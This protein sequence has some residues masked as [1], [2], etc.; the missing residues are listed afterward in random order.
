MPLFRIGLEMIPV[1]KLRVFIIQVVILSLLCFA[2][3]GEA[4]TL[5]RGPYL[6]TATSTGIIVK[7]RVALSDS[8]L[9]SVHYGTSADNLTQAVTDSNPVAIAFDCGDGCTDPQLE[10]T[11]QLPGLTP[12]TRYYYSIGTLSETLAEPEAE[13]TFMTSP[14][15]G[16]PVPTRVWVIGDSG[17]FN[18]DSQQ[19]RDAYKTYTG[20]RQTDVWLTLGDNAYDNGTDREFQEGLFELYPEI[21]RNTP[22]WPSFGNHDGRSADSSDQ[23]GPYYDIFN[24]PKNG[25]AGGLASG[26]EAY[27]SYDYGNIHFIVLDSVESD[28]S[29]GSPMLTWLESDLQ[30]NEIGNG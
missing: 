3:S 16:T 6:Q 10:M 28:M 13:G 29:V 1:R 24:L 23:S 15:P 19:V 12:D 26:T 30:A 8:T 4:Q 5:K 14:A 9:D 27:Y 18:A 21:L 11:V 25:E 22:F 2:Q 17:W 20:L 7:W